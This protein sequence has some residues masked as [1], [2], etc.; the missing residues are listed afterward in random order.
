M[1]LG[2]RESLNEGDRSAFV[3][4]GSGAGRPENLFDEH[5]RQRGEHV[6]VECGE[7]TQR[8]RERQDPL[9]NG[10]ARQHAIGEVRGLVAHAAVGAT[11]ADCRG[12]CTRT[13]SADPAGIRHTGSRASLR[14]NWPHARYSQATAELGAR[15]REAALTFSAYSNL[16]RALTNDEGL[17]RKHGVKTPGHRKGPLF[18]RPRKTADASLGSP[19]ATPA[20]TVEPAL[21]APVPGH[22]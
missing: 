18:H 21:S 20:A 2:R 4:L 6:G 22:G 15:A 8:E 5:A 16:V 12:A 13:R 14:S 19:A 7:A 9:S 3:L 11:R 17:R 10:H 1:R